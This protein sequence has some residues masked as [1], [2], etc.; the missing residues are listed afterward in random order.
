V[1]Y[2]GGDRLIVDP[3]PYGSRSSLTGNAISA[4]S[5]TVPDAYRPSQSPYAR[6]DLPWA[7]ATEGGVVAARADLAGAFGNDTEPS[8]VPFARRDWTF[9]PEGE[10]VAIARVRRGDASRN[11]YLRFR[12]PASLSQ[13]D[14]GATG[15]LGASRVA[16]HA[17]AR[18]G[19]TPSVSKI[20]VDD[21]WSSANYG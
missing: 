19:G 2:R 17:V 12:S 9:L 21:C 7:R 6:A 18:S 8:D 11:T 5:A 13:T 16:I 10:A 15:T 1:L 14:D 20:A 3:S 4:D